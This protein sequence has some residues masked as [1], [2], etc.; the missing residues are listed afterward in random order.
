[1]SEAEAFSFVEELKDEAIKMLREMVRIDTVV[2][3]GRGYEEMVRFLEPIFSE[4][5]FETERVTVPEEKVREIPL[6][7]E[8]PRVNLVARRR[9]DKPPL[10]IYAHMD[11]VPVEERWSVPPF[12]GVVRNGRIYGRGVADMKGFIA[13]VITALRVMRELGLEPNYDIT[14]VMCTDEEVGVYPGV[15]YLTDKGYIRGDVICGEMIHGVIGVGFAGSIHFGV[16]VKGRSA[17]TG[18]WWMAVNA[19]E[20]ALPVLEEVLRLRE[21]V[22]ARRSNVPTI[23]TPFGDK[24][25]PILSVNVIAGGVKENIIP[26]ECRFSVDRRYIPEED[27][28]QVISEFIEAV[29]AGKARSNA[30]D[31]DVNVVRAYKPFKTSPENPIVRKLAEAVMHVTGKQPAFIG[32]AGATDMGYVAQKGHNVAVMG[33]G[34]AASNFHGADENIKIEDMLTYAKELIHLLCFQH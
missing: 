14:C 10:T 27:E 28:E 21:R 17:H 4:L 24:L 3:P 20:N 16:T 19:I 31:V 12:E 22:T 13:T 30:L 33:V 8:G 11:V 18:M 7:L 6:P 29:M 23:P 15:Y 26:G 5:G 25:I 2:P 9:A 1:M 34:D 32:V